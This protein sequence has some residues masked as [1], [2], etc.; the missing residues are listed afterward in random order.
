MNG[1]SQGQALNNVGAYAN[2]AV[3]CKED[4]YTQSAE[5]TSDKMVRNSE[6]VSHADTILDLATVEFSE[7]GSQTVPLLISCSRDTTVK[8]WR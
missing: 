8:V 2:A 1:L 6:I 4:S 3:D 7:S 5:Q